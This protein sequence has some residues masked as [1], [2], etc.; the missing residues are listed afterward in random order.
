MLVRIN[1]FNVYILL[2]VGFF[3]IIKYMKTN[4][5]EIEHLKLEIKKIIERNKK[6]ETDK[7][8]ETSLTRRVFIAV[9]TYILV[10]V[11][12]ISIG[13]EKPFLTAIVPAVAYLVSTISL[14]IIKSW[15]L[16]QR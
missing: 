12:L 8:W 1:Y 10:V 11:L 16:K 6:V 13:A 2:A 3:G 14:T 5:D 4:I 15:W 9:S 7:A